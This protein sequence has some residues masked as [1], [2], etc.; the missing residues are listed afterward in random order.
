[1]LKKIRKFFEKDIWHLS[2][3]KKPRSHRILFRQIRIFLVA[4]RGFNEDRVQL[5]AS[6]LTYFTLLS[7]VPIFA[8]VFGI[9]KG[10]GFDQGLEGW[11]KSRLSAPRD[12]IQ[13]IIN[14]AVGYLENISG[15]FIAGIGLVVLIFSVMKVLGNIENAFNDIW[16]I[17]KSRVFSRKFSD[18]ISLIVIA[19]VLLFL[20]SSLTGFISSQIK[21]SGGGPL[22]GYIGPL[23]TVLVSVIPFLLIWMV[24]TLL[25]IIMPNTKVKFGSAFI[26]G[27]IAG[28][29]F[30]LLQW[31]YFNFQSLL[32]GYRA[33]Y[34]S[35]AALPLFLIWLNI[36]WL[37]VLFGAEISFSNQNIEH[38]ESEFESF[39][40]SISSRKKFALIITHA[41][42]KNFVNGENAMTAGQLSHNL[43]IPVRVVREIIYN[44]I[45][46][47]IL[48]ETVTQDSNE[49][50]YQPARDSSV[51]TVGSVIDAIE[52]TGNNQIAV[53]SNR[54]VNEID[55]VLDSFVSVIKKSPQNKLIRDI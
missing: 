25:Y 54:E 26:A 44:L 40:I 2:L 27:I 32:S 14:T 39:N 35:L 5:R 13:W 46:A 1:M 47:G 3:V 18:Y 43:G 50:A 42:V 9:A 10:L 38:F 16:Q 21:D 15:G 55:K 6:A 19:P 22:L 30:Q 12:A 4:I 20:S 24:F 48:T 45:D 23:L 33:I 37:I 8:M 49:S 17:K 41:V 29:M 7:I 51:L 31:G 52:N 53:E 28:T 34:G 11:I 36:S